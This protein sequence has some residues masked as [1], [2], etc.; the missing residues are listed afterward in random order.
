M[1]HHLRKKGL[2][3]KRA[4]IGMATSGLV[5]KFYQGNDVKKGRDL[6]S[7]RGVKSKQQSTEKSSGYIEGS[8]VL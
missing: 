8:E 7:K 1:Y 5:L 4:S 6:A 3:S 2:K